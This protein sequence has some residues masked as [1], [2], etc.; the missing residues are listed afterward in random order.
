MWDSLVLRALMPS[1]VKRFLQRGLWLVSSVPGTEYIR[2]EAEWIACGGPE[3]VLRTLGEGEPPVP[4]VPVRVLPVRQ[5]G[6]HELLEPG[7]TE[8][9]RA[10]RGR[11]RFGPGA[12][13]GRAPRRWAALGWAGAELG[14]Y[15]QGFQ[16]DAGCRCGM[17]ES[18]VT[19]RAGKGVGM[20]PPSFDPFVK[21]ARSA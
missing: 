19:S 18:V 20:R 3:P 16:G 13:G 14:L 6:A 21:A 1:A 4:A 7:R 8:H 10:A 2:T 15:G 17:T 11:T 9:G 12:P 5:G